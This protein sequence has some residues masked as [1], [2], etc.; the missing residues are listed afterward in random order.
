VAAVIDFARNG[1]R[2]LLEELEEWLDDLEL[3]AARALDRY[4][5]ARELRS[6]AL[7]AA[8]RL[9]GPLIDLEDVLAGATDARERARLRSL[10]VRLAADDDDG[11]ETP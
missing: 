10:L 1:R 5:A 7:A 2:D 3:Q 11:P 6:A 4:E 8:E 9:R